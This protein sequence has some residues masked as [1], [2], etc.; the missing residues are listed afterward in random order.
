MKFPGFELRCDNQYIVVPES[1]F[2]DEHGEIHSYA[3]DER[4]C[5]SVP[6]VTPEQL[7]A[8]LARLGH[9]V[10]VEVKQSGKRKSNST[11]PLYLSTL[12][13][14]ANGHTFPEGTRNDRLYQAAVD[15]AANGYTYERTYEMLAPIA[16][17][18]G[19]IQ[20]KVSS[21][22]Q[23]AFSKPRTSYK[24]VDNPRHPHVDMAYRFVQEYTWHGRS[25]ST[26]RM[27]FL[28][29]LQCAARGMGKH[30]VYRGTIREIM[31]LAR[32]NSYHTI[33]KSLKRM[34]DANMIVDARGTDTHGYHTR[35]YYHTNKH[36]DVIERQWNTS[37]RLW[38]FGDRVLHTPP[39]Q[40]CNTYPIRFWENTVALSAGSDATERQALGLSG[41]LI[42]RTLLDSDSGHTTRQ[43]NE[44]TGFTLSQGRRA[45]DRLSQYALVTYKLIERNAKLWFGVP[46]TL[47][48][49]QREVAI[50]T[51]AADAARARRTRL[52]RARGL[53]LGA[54][55][56]DARL[57]HDR[58]RLL[59]PEDGFY[60]T[61]G[62]KPKLDR[63]R[64]EN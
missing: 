14:L 18:S 33:L 7:Q 60:Y 21:T 64:R 36:G 27:V 17:Q 11:S 22:I 45:V 53:Y 19:E 4:T 55:L 43:L 41:T 47:D 42:Y 15:M 40:K 16:L 9:V 39:C 59:R 34:V 54:L 49:L 32:L 1:K 31:E 3:W 25:A 44:I 13:Y 6:E 52:Q 61:E 29:L 26:D 62:H 57:R 24:Q 51:G 37:Q 56:Y 10:T 35:R 38:R 20:R 63:V 50:P 28:A 12:D 30:G 58:D 46:K 23:S 8:I 5:D 2:R 48:E